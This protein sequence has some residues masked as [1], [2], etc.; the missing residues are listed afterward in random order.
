MFFLFL[1]VL[2]MSDLF[3]SSLFPHR[4]LSIFSI[5]SVV[6]S[7]FIPCGNSYACLRRPASRKAAPSRAVDS[8]IGD[9]GRRPLLTLNFN[10]TRQTFFCLPFRGPRLQRSLFLVTGIQSSTST[11]TSRAGDFPHFTVIHASIP[12]CLHSRPPSSAALSQ[13]AL[14]NDTHVAHTTTTLRITTPTR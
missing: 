10:L 14:T 13:S 9:D 3:S 1:S 11:S 12:E 7:P 4:H 5:L 6:A 2:L 8:N